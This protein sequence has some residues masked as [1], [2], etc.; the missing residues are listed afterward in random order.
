M[1]KKQ[2]VK[3]I[4]LLFTGFMAMQVLQVS[5]SVQ[6]GKKETRSFPDYGKVVAFPGAEGYGKDAT[7]G[8]YGEVY[9]VTN[10]KDSGE[11]SFRDAVSQP[12]RF[13]LF[14][15]AGIIQVQ[16][17]I[18][19]AKN[20]TIAGHSA[21]G[22]GVVLYGNTV[23]FSGADNLICRYLRV[24]MGVNGDH[25]KDAAGIAFG[26][27]MIFD[28]MSVTWGLD[29]NFSINHARKGHEGDAPRNITIQNSIMG[30]GLHPH[31]CGGLIQ[32][33]SDNG[34][35]LYRNLYIDN[36]TRNPKVKGLNQFVNNVVYNWGSGAAYNMGGNSE[37]ISKSVLQNNYFIEGACVNYDGNPYKPSRPLIGYNKNVYTYVEGNYFDD[38][39]DGKLNG[40]LLTQEDMKM[41]KDG[42]TIA[43]NFVTEPDAKHPQI[44]GLMSAQ[45]A[46]QWIAKWSG[47]SLPARDEVD[48]YLIEELT[49]LGKKGQIIRSEIEQTPTKGPGS[50]QNG[51]ML[52]DSDKDGMPDAFEDL[53]GLDKNDPSDAMKL[54]SNGYTNLEN[55]L[56]LLEKE[57]QEAKK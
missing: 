36:K 14:D 57:K 30:Q 38:N 48:T 41:T 4:R 16:S 23:S 40:R 31:S 17:P 49:S 39:R 5:A 46:Y 22:D 33:T 8:R 21:P 44:N 50:I 55:Y 24:R 54:A 18:T 43:P 25:G 15:V 53:Y 45:E 10:L 12:N 29:E 51:P 42:S 6:E 34:V 32:T 37:S 7:G 28:H 2:S 52:K 27:N 11:G 20:I 13:I 26:Q 35:T 9:H 19:V 47:A 1:K 3:V 56:F